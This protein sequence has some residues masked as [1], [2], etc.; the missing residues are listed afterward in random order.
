LGFIAL[1]YEKHK[2][3]LPDNKSVCSCL[4]A[5]KVIPKS[6]NHRL[7]TLVQLLGI[8]VASAHRAL[9]DSR[10]CLEVALQC[11]QKVGSDATLEKVFQTQ[12]GALEWKSYS[13]DDLLSQE[14][15]RSL[16]EAARKQLVL[17]I[18]YKGGSQPGAPRRIT[19]QGLVR[20]PLG[21]YVVGL[22]HKENTEKRFYLNRILSAKILD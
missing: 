9:D 10:A 2:M 18:T 17:E 14:P 5:Q 13:M 22:C 21:D 4:L 20:N 19:P 8:K 16:V 11:M 3:A 6:I 1:E 12:G 7:A 15:T